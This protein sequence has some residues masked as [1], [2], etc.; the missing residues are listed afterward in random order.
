MVPK[1]RTEP[2]VALNGRALEV[3]GLA[4]DAVVSKVHELVVK[5]GGVIVLRS[6]P[7]ISI[8][9]EPDLQGTPTSHYDP[10]SDIEFFAMH[11]QGIFD[12]LLDNPNSV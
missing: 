1:L 8:V 3:C 11:N 6:K 5:S 7:Q 2:H 4:G 12:V 10:L 9:V